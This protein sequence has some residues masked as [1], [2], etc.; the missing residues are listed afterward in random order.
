MH[1]PPGLDVRP[2]SS[3]V[4]QAFFNILGTRVVGASFLDIFAGSGLMGFEALSRGASYVAF[5]EENRNQGRA[6]E[7]TIKMFGT[8]GRAQNAQVDGEAELILGDFR[9]VLPGLEGKFKFDLIFAD[10][11]YKLHYGATVLGLVEKHDLLGEGGLVIIEHLR[12]DPLPEA[13]PDG[14]LVRSD[15]R[16]YGQTGLTFFSDSKEA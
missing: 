11:P 12:G 1:C 15:Q 3:K 4:R 7:Q 13:S 8:D 5:V 9:R 2:T 16:F 6:I 10:P 14:N